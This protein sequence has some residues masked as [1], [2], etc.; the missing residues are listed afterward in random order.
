MDEVWEDETSEN[1]KNESSSNKISLKNEMNRYFNQGY[2][3]G[4][5]EAKR[6]YSPLGSNENYE[7]SAFI[8]IKAGRLLG[9]LEGLEFYLEKWGETEEN[10][11]NFKKWIKRMKKQIEINKI[12]TKEYL[13]SDG[14]L[15]YDKHPVLEEI[16][17]EIMI[18]LEN[19][20]CC[21]CIN[22]NK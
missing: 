7:K 21:K 9:S 5:T 16:E 10:I 19:I 12:F 17:R 6:V 18:Y 3:E 14:L 15:R 8:G 22:I 13:E 4:L 11:E 1:R 20:K 2:L